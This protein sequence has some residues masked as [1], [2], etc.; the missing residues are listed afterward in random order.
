MFDQFVS[1]F[2]WLLGAY[3][4]AGLLFA[5]PFALFGVTRID[6]DAKG[7]SVGFRL[8]ITPGVVVFWPM[9]L[10]RWLSGVSEPPVERNAHR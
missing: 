3:A 6:P 2:L 8:L 9:L 10:R 4:L 5:I 7:T 1:G